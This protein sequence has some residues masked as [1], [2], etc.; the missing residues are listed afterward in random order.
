MKIYKVSR[1]TNVVNYKPIEENHYPLCINV[2]QN[3]HNGVNFEQ[4]FLSK[5]KADELYNQILDGIFHGSDEVIKNGELTYYVNN[6]WDE[7]GNPYKTVNCVYV[8][9][10][11]VTE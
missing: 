4:L 1:K 2:E 8:E 5:G 3:Y 6:I 9:E 11:E 10:I 7:N